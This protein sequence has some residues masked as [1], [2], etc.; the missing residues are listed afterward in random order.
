MLYRDGFYEATIMLCRS[1]A[2]MICYERLDGA[3]HPFG[4]VQDVE[5]RNFRELLRWLRDIRY[6][7]LAIEKLLHGME[8]RRTA[9]SPP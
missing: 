6:S 9:G 8:C 7:F 5:R 4:T 1:T 3:A 2:E